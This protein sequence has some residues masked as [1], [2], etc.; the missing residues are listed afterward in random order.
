MPKITALSARPP[1]VLV[2]GGAGGCSADAAW[3]TA[4]VD[5]LE[6]VVNAAWRGLIAGQSAIESVT[7]AV[8]RLED[9]EFF[10]AGVGARLQSDGVCRL[11]ASLMDGSRH[12]FSA[13]LLA[14]HI[15]HPSALAAALQG[16]AESVL[17]PAGAQLLARELGISPELPVTP[18]RAQEW[19]AHLAE[20]R[21]E[22]SGGTVGAVVLD[23]AGHL[24]AATSTGGGGFNFPERVSDSGTV[25]GNYAST[26]AAV[27]CTGI[28]EQIVDE[29]VAVR[30]ETR[31]R[32]G[33]TII[34]ASNLCLD[35]ALRRQRHYGWIGVDRHGNWGAYW[36]TEDM[37]WAARS[38]EMERCA[39]GRD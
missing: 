24:A 20:G 11:T 22:A 4:R 17:G 27:S 13:V 6:E 31:V 37:L 33:M 18:E 23:L 38:G 5:A 26:W 3:R 14:T 35:E 1:V 29:G 25:A 36:T 9:S 10:N 28:G 16:R 21:Q 39:S 2:H 8:K 32:D 15:R 7:D 19:A 12:K 34:E 30:L